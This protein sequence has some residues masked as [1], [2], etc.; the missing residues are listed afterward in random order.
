MKIRIAALT[1]ALSLLVLASRTSLP[2]SAQEP[3]RTKIDVPRDE[4]DKILLEAKEDKEGATGRLKEK[5]KELD[6]QHDDLVYGLINLRM[7]LK[8]TVDG[9]AEL[10]AGRK[11]DAKRA[12]SDADA[13]TQQSKQ[14]VFRPVPAPKTPRERD[15][16]LKKYA[17]QAALASKLDAEASYIM[18]SLTKE[19]RDK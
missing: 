3:A 8:R 1:M 2:L 12:G 14:E 19:L 4:V 5:I 7:R 16:I 13:S 17:D 6:K 15:E 18:K 10:E 11:S 9:L